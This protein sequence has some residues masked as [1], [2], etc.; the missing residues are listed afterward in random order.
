MNAA[1]SIV[2]GYGV[3]IDVS[4]LL[5]RLFLGLMIFAH[6]FQKFFRGGRIAGTA[7]WFESIGM[8]PGRLNAYLAAMTELGVGVLMT[9]G[10][11]TPLASA[12]L[13]ALMVVAIVTVHRRN[14][15]FNFNSGQ[16][17]EYNLAIMIMALVPATLGAGRFS[18]DHLWHPYHWSHTTGL[19]VAVLLGFV[20]AA[21]QLA[22]VYRP[23][24]QK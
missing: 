7:G 11:A 8:K 6:G 15:F 23:P 3:A 20:G 16:G 1:Q 10:L 14:G 2:S 5:V 21:A 22:A 9:L 17:V 13:I 19:V 18:L 12:G 4:L 24:Q